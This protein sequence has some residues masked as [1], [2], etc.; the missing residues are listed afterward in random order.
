MK[1]SKELKDILEAIE[2]WHKKHKGNVQ[3]IASFIAFKGEDF[4]KIEDVF[5]AYGDKDLMRECFKEMDEEVEKEKG[6]FV[7]W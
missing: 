6:D 3:F 7:N 4:D 2:R 5:K 1:I